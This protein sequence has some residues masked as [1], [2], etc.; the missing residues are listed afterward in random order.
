[1]IKTVRLVS[2][3]TG[4]PVADATFSLESSP[5]SPAGSYR[6]KVCDETQFTIEQLSHTDV[7]V[8]ITDSIPEQIELPCNGKCL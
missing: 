4:N 8:D 6:I 3:C 5:V 2:E 7:I 1:M